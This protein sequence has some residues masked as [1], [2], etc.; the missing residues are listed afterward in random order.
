VTSCRRSSRSTRTAQA[1]RK[2]PEHVLLLHERH[3]AAVRQAAGAAGRELRD[4]QSRARE[5]LRRGRL[6]PSCNFLPPAM[7]GY[8]AYSP[9]PWGDPNGRA[10]IRRPR[11]SSGRGRQRSQGDGV[12]EQQG[13][14]VP[15]SASNLRSTLNQIGAEC[16]CEDAQ[17]AG[18][19]LDDR[20]GEHEGP[21]RLHRLVPGLPPRATS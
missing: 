11:R 10:N 20:E 6:K 18:L 13:H 2:H 21:D 16:V 4:R 19:L 17:P 7:V 14:R 5:D 9:C 12:D 1:R 15:R 3:G 8:Q